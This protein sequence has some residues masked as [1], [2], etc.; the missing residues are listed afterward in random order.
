MP[1]AIELA[2]ARASL[3]SIPEIAAHLDERFRLLTTGSRT[4]LPRHRT[5][6]ASVDWSYELLSERERRFFRQLSVFAGGF[7]LAAAE[8]I[9]AEAETIERL[10]QLVEKSLISHDLGS[11]ES[12][13]RLLETLRQYAGE[14]LKETGEEPSARTRHLEFFLRRAEGVRVALRS[15]GAQKWLDRLE[16]DLDNFRAALAWALGSGRTTESLR[17]AAALRGFWLARGYWSEGRAHLAAALARVEPSQRTSEVAT[18]LSA[19]GL[20]AM[21]QSE[22]ATARGL[23]E[24]ALAIRRDLADKTELEFELV[25]LGMV[26]MFQCD[27]AAAQSVCEEAL[28]WSRQVGSREQ[29]ASALCVLGKIAYQQGRLDEAW[30]LHLEALALRREVSSEAQIIF[31]LCDVGQ[32]LRRRGEYERAL[33]YYQEALALGRAARIPSQIAQPLRHLGDLAAE[34]GEFS[35]AREWYAEALEI[36]V[37]LGLLHGIATILEGIA[38]VGA[39][40]GEPTWAARL[41]ARSAALREAGGFPVFPIE[42]PEVEAAAAS[43][44][45]ALGEEAFAAVWAEGQTLSLED[46]CTYVRRS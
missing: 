18:A 3:L 39:A 35:R 29:A 21:Y 20:M 15:P 5:L 14:R 26:L 8:A 27:Y 23:H 9:G 37:K 7:D 12:R 46:A 30:P 25:N 40:Q 42:R 34:Q 38:T 1:L 17:L 36:C 10:G 11:G 16:Q 33:Q 28:A 45:A 6:R 13:Y 31:S 22:M 2:A 24:R 43:A 4:A 32:V 44:C 41:L 19:A